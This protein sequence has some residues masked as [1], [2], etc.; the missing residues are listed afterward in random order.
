METLE[1]G[2]SSC[3]LSRMS[4]DYAVVMT[5]QTNCALRHRYTC[6]SYDGTSKFSSCT[7]V[8]TPVVRT[9]GLSAAL[10][11]WRPLRRGGGLAGC[12]GVS[13]TVTERTL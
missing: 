2:L 11:D 9:R 12:R 5:S 4:R 6:S 10:P 1:G 13:P 8:A 7:D 3:L